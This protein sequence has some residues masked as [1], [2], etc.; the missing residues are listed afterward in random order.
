[1][2]KKTPF[3]YKGEIDEKL[4]VR[5]RTRRKDKKGFQNGT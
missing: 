4:V 5:G 2:G 1:M 3:P